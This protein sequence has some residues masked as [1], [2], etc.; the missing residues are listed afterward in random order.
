MADE[1]VDVAAVSDKVS[2]SMAHV[3]AHANIA[4]AVSDKVSIAAAHV[5]ANTLTAAINDKV[6]I[7]AAHVQA[8]ANIAA[9]VLDKVAVL[10][11]PAVGVVLTAAIKDKVKVTMSWVE[12]DESE[13]QFKHRFGAKIRLDAGTD[14]VLTVT[15]EDICEA[16]L[17]G[18]TQSDTFY[19]QLDAN[20]IPIEGLINTNW[21]VTNVGTTLATA[22][23]AGVTG[24]R[25]VV[26]AIEI[27]SDYR[28]AVVTLYQGTTKLVEF[29]L[30]EPE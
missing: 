20:H 4:A 5:R 22:T 28:L 10:M 29:V 25:H 11:Y 30:N 15:G 24:D 26:T 12:L 8:H 1:F 9:A 16:I 23:K 19:T 6:S 3:Q 21:L 18:F 14:A 2:V 17:E 13:F 7:A 27:T